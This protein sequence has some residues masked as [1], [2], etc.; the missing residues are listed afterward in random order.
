[1][2]T[3]DEMNI[4]VCREFQGGLNLLCRGLTLAFR[5]DLRVA[6]ET[7]ID[8]LLQAAVSEARGIDGLDL[9]TLQQMLSDR[10]H[11]YIRRRG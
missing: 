9:P 2:R 10:W 1:M 8:L 4:E 7:I 3:E 11:E 6:Q 5:D